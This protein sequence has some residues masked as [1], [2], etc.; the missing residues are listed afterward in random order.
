KRQQMAVFLMKAKHGLCYTP[1]SCVGV[2]PDVPCSSTFA[3]WIE[4]L[5]AEGVTSGCGGGNFCP[6]NLVTRR[7]MAV[8]LMKSQHGSAGLPRRVRRRGVTRRAGG[9]LHRT[10]RGGADHGRLLGLASDVLPRRDEHART[11]GGVHHED[12]PPAVNTSARWPDSSKRRI[13]AG[14]R[15]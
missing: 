13:S 9:R 3:P 15:Q 10:A 7:Q 2:F 1:P 5:A 14:S 8:F 11:D 12:V 4:A 6:D